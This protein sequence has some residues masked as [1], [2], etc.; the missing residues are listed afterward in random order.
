M[1]YATQ[2]DIAEIYGEETLPLL[3]GA[4]ERTIDAARVNRAL[5]EVS[6]LIDSYPRRALQ[7][8]HS[9]QPAN[10]GAGGGRLGCCATGLKRSAHD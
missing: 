8:A 3:A 6:L 10:P 5:S 9:P 7:P 1:P 2:A 4:E